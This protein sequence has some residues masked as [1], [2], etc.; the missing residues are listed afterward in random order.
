MQLLITPFSST[1]SRT[2]S[3]TPALKIRIVPARLPRIISPFFHKGSAISQPTSGG[4][5]SISAI[6]RQFSSVTVCSLEAYADELK[7]TSVQGCPTT[8]NL[9]DPSDLSDPS[10]PSDLC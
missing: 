6:Q 7:P 9:W 5:V 10:D 3:A 8:W 2:I 1:D 4:A